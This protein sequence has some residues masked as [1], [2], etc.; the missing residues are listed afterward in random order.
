MAAIMTM[1]VTMVFFKEVIYHH[2]FRGELCPEGVAL[3]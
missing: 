1:G 3:L 2:E